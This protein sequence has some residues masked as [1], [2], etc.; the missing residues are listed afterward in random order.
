MSGPVGQNVRVAVRVRPFNQREI[1]RTSKCCIRM[2]GNRTT[3]TDPE[4]GKSKDFTFDFSY[5]SHSPEDASFATQETVFNDLGLDCLA[6]AWQGYNVSL[7]AYG[8]V[9]TCCM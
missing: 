7:F 3:I 5:W 1:D 8:Q 6:S 2:D 9:R 4:T